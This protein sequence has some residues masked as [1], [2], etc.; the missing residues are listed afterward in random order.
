[1]VTDPSGSVV[2]DAQ[3]TV[4]NE[5]TGATIVVKSQSGGVYTAPL[6]LPGTYTV[7]VTKQ[8]F[9]RWSATSIRVDVTETAGLNIK[10]EIGAVTE[11]VEV[12]AEGSALQTESS[13]LGHVTNAETIQNLPLAVR[14]YTQI[15]GLNPNVQVDVL[16]AGALGRGPDI[17]DST[18]V[19]N[20]VPYY[21]NNVQMDG[22]EIND[23]QEYGN[24]FSS[25]VAIPNPDS[26]QEFKVQTSQYD[27]TFG[28]DAGANV[29]V[30]TKSGSNKFH[31]NVW[32]YFRNTVLN[33]NSY[34]LNRDG[35]PRGVFNQNQYGGDI[36]GPILKS[37]LFFF[38]S[39]QGTHQRNGVDVN[40]CSGSVVGLTGL[41][42]DR[43]ESGLVSWAEGSG[44]L[45]GV[46]GGT[47][48]AMNGSNV[49]PQAL[50]IMNLKLSNGTYLVPTPPA[51]SDSIAESVPC[52]FVE[53]Q[54]ITN[55]DYVQNDKS[56][57]SAKFFFANDTAT[58]TIPT[59]GQVPGLPVAD[60]NNYRNF[61][62]THTYTFSPSLLN[63]AQ[64]GFH[65]TYGLFASTSP[66]SMAIL[67]ATV[68]GF[69]NTYPTIALDTG[70]LISGAPDGV[71]VEPAV[72]NTYDAQD[73]LTYNVGK[74]FLRLGGGVT[75]LHLNGFVGLPLFT[76]FGSPADF[77]LG[78]CGG[79][80]T[81]L[82]PGSTTT[83]GNGSGFSNIEFGADQP[84][85]PALQDLIDWDFNAYVQDDFKV[86]SRL[87]LNLG[88]RYDRVGY[89]G[90]QRGRNVG[91]NYNLITPYSA[92]ATNCTTVNGTGSLLGYTVPSNFPGTPPCQ[93]QRIGSEAGFNPDGRNNT[94]NPRFGFAWRIPH[95]ERVVL[96]GGYG[97]YRSILDGNTQFNSVLGQPFVLAR[98]FS[99]NSLAGT[100]ASLSQ[101][102]APFTVTLPFYTPYTINSQSTLDTLD[103]NLRPPKIQEYGLNVQIQMMKDMLLEVGYS[104]NRGEHLFNTD[105]LNEACLVGA[106]INQDGCP[107]GIFPP[108]F[109]NT[110]GNAYLRAPYLGFATGGIGD[111]E[112]QASD[113]YNALVTTLTKRFSHGL[114]FQ[115]SYT[116]SK[117]METF[118]GGTSN[119]GG[120]V[121]GG[122]FGASG[123]GDPNHP[124][125][126]PDSTIR[127][128][129]FVASWVYQLPGPKNRH[130]FAGQVLGGW[131]WSGVTTYQ[132]GDYLTIG[133]SNGSNGNNI[134]GIFRHNVASIN[135]GCTV[136]QLVNPGTIQSKVDDYFNTACIEPPAFT[137]AQLAA[138]N[139]T[140]PATPFGD[141]GAG[142]VRGPD[143]ANWDMSLGK[144]VGIPWPNEAATVEF[145]ADFFNAFNHTQFQN[146]NVVYSPTSTSFGTI[147]GVAVSPRIIQFALRFNF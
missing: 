60:V 119:Y 76:E 95:T 35:K 50:A 85:S 58:L 4:T 70:L 22:V 88:F 71:S 97:I 146:P 115:L 122:S 25:G 112:T 12:Q 98:G 77:L 7:E 133:L 118:A 8:G 72:Q 24:A 6:L 126:G 130:S 36:G 17:S 51:G 84:G 111:F 47:P 1:M 53:N 42:N 137:P 15:I 31:G 63:Q 81:T 39:Y 92:P 32:E 139:I 21:D 99:A 11:K 26:I 143:Q 123:L 54:F 110:V 28:R 30:V 100:N 102:I 13:A 96:R 83:Y 46:N 2:L 120:S 10:L 129:R 86:T 67:G 27:A 16:N 105:A 61:S 80:T 107:A 66:F 34:F 108:G 94:W 116:F 87:T 29:N 147:T 124:L 93:V 3:I 68:P 55:V 75:H 89:E 57:F 65:R 134:Y 45:T 69:D 90:D 79:P 103:P 141:I 104:G 9:K 20:G 23:R 14:N 49:S 109:A 113:W 140:G 19:A 144:H 52:P 82:C 121:T 18:V 38:G 101:P 73:T 40:D 59:V 127:P 78:A 37:K 138:L 135:P 91:F 56:K 131:V 41:T 128:Q 106:P 44:G 5:A 136:K 74:H 117:E 142:N 43:S 48:L 62:L 132:A 114:Q 145:R 125:Y 64:V 33:A